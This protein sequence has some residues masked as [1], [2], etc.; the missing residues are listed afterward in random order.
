MLQHSPTH[1]YLKLSILQKLSVKDTEPSQKCD[2]ET[3]ADQA[4]YETTTTALSSHNTDNYTLH[5]RVC[6]THA[7]AMM[8]HIA[9]RIDEPQP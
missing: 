4:E 9:S 8:H 7:A 2:I 1:T 5:R 3:C 6:A